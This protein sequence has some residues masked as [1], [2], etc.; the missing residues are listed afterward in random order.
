MGR[1]KIRAVG[2]SL[3]D[4]FNLKEKVQEMGINKLDKKA[5]FR[6]NLVE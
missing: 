1:L 6:I 4:G 5:I 3:F 2:L